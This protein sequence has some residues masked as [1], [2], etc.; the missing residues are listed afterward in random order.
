ML[1]C[2]VHW[3]GGRGGD[4]PCEQYEYTSDSERSRLSLFV[5]IIQSVQNER[6]MNGGLAIAVGHF[7]SLPSA[8]RDTVSDSL[9]VLFVRI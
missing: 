2:F 4:N 8:E 9:H 1:H 3:G 5:P 7:V 6:H